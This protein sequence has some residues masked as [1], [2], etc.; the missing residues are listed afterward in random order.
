VSTR[1]VPPV[2]RGRQAE[3]IER[4][5]I[6][7]RMQNFVEAER[8]ALE[9]LR[10]SRT[11]VVAT[12]VLGRALLAQNRAAEAVGPLEKA[13]RRTN[14]PGMETLLGAALGESGRRQEAIEQ[15]HRTAARRP[16]FLPAFQ[17]LAGQLAKDRRLDEAIATIGSAL[18][19]APANI[20]LQLDLAR[21]HLERNARGEARAVL[22]EAHKAH[23]GRPD[24]AT[25]LARLMRQDGDYAAAAETYR[26]ALGLRPDDAMTRADLAACL[27]EMDEREAAEGNL[28][29][30]LRGRPQ[31]LAKGAYTLVHSSHGR[32]FFRPS[33]LKRYLHLDKP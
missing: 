11:E 5:S 7:L 21:L 26:L 19:L 3:L 6:A 9:V 17:E 20:D 16:P 15:L 24:I 13:A 25:L 12:W 31:M 8:L 4:A 28:R 2:R 14:D 10:A 18:T 23:P 33:A 22:A 29:S 30:A 32:F 27:F 1:P